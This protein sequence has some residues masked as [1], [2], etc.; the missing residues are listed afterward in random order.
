M[1]L[2]ITETNNA[3]IVPLEI[4]LEKLHQLRE[5]ITELKSIDASEATTLKSVTDKKT[6]DDE[7]PK[8]QSKSSKKINPD[9]A[10]SE[11]EHALNDAIKKYFKK[12]TKGSQET[13]NFFT[14]APGTIIRLLAN[15]YVA[16]ALVAAGLG[17]QILNWLMIQGNVLDRHFKRIIADEILAGV[18]RME[19]QKTQ[20]GL[21]RNVIFTS[22][23]GSTEPEFAFNSYEA[24]RTGEIA[25]TDAFQIRRG[26]RF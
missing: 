11:D 19:R 21:G 24:V 2:T 6:T 23:S 8:K 9:Y 5:L 22:H 18:R 26:Y 3:I 12:G 14:D 20:A 15:P 1:S 10:S 4:K 17:T 25:Q 7:S 13:I 16:A